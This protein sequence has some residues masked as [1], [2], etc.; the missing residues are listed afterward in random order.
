MIDLWYIVCGLYDI[1]E[2]QKYCYILGY[3]EIIVII[4]TSVLIFKLYN[5]GN[6]VSDLYVIVNVDLI[7]E[8]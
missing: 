8:K 4:Y 5:S 2:L 1:Q 3:R 7:A 6:S